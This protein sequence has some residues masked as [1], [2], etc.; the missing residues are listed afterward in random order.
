MVHERAQQFYYLNA[1]TGA[2]TW[3]KPERLGVIEIEDPPDEWV[4]LYDENGGKY[5]YHQLTGRTAWM[6]E[7]EAATQEALERR[8]GRSSSAATARQSLEPLEAWGEPCHRQ[9]LAPT[10]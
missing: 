1:V 7:A 2:V 10:V 9:G 6:T 4:T 3:T 8:R 5:Y